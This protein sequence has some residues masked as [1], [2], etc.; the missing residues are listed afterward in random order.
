MLFHPTWHCAPSI[1]IKKKF[2]LPSTWGNFIVNIHNSTHMAHQATG[3]LM[4]RC[5]AYEVLTHSAEVIRMDILNSCICCCIFYRFIHKR[6][7]L[8]PMNHEMQC[9][10][11]Y[12]CKTNWILCW[13]VI[14]K[15]RS[16]LPHT[17]A[18]AQNRSNRIFYSLS[19]YQAIMAPRSTAYSQL[20]CTIYFV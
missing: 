9:E 3:N 1:C 4:C 16:M 5:F 20:S 19:L 11:L 17:R 18:P 2:T 12:V 14:M 7:C 6:N 10:M 8:F 15:S 13:I